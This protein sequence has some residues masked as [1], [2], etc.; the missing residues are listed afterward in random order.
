MD[1]LVLQISGCKLWKLYEDQLAS[2]P[3][4]DS[5]FRVIDDYGRKYRQFALR[6]G[7]TLYIPRGYLHEAATNCS[8]NEKQEPS[9]HL[10]I[11]IEVANT[12]S[13][14][15]FLHHLFN[16]LLTFDRSCGCHDVDIIDS[17][18]GKD[19]HLFLSF[20]PL[21]IIHTVLHVAAAKAPILRKSLYS[22]FR[23]ICGLNEDELSTVNRISRKCLITFITEAITNF[24]DALSSELLDDV[25]R[26][27]NKLSDEKSPHADHKVRKPL[28]DRNS[29][30]KVDKSS[31]QLHR[32]LLNFVNIN[33]LYVYDF[34]TPTLPILRGTT[35]TFS[36]VSSSYYFDCHI[37]KCSFTFSEDWLKYQILSQ[38]S[39]FLKDHEGSSSSIFIDTLSRAILTSL[40][41]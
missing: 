36:T 22:S 2:F 38:T 5:V 40:L 17:I 20:S 13:V 31:K 21:E 3:R 14:E 6:P 23:H 33:L 34:Y 26:L 4:Q 32:Q 19:Y 7:A 24:I 35:D 15:I 16:R 28:T 9:I 30:Q 11:G 39:L 10:T 18:E 37:K 27:I 1:G 8:E 29:P 12:G 41:I 25:I